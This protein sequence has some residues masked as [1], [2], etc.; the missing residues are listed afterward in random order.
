M[1]MTNKDFSSHFSDKF[2]PGI[3]AFGK[4]ALL[5]EG[6]DCLIVTDREDKEKAYCT[7]CKKWVT[8]PANT[9]HT[10]SPK[11]IQ[12]AERRNYNMHC[13]H[14]AWGMT[15]AGI[16]KEKAKKE[17]RL[18]IENRKHAICPVCKNTYEVYH[19]WR[20]NMSQLDGYISLSVWD[21]SKTE[22]GAV[23]M[24]RIE[25][26][27]EYGN[28]TEPVVTDTY[29]D[30]ER[31]LF[32][33]GH[34]TVRQN[35]V[36]WVKYR[37]VWCKG[38]WRKVKQQK[39]FVKSIIDRA[40]RQSTVMWSDYVHGH[41]CM[42]VGSL[43][44]AIRGTPYKYLFNG[45]QSY[46]KNYRQY[47]WRDGY[48]L[49][50]VALMDLYSLH[51]WVELL[52]KNGMENIV[53]NHI[54]RTGCKNA[55][56][57]A[58]KSIK[59]AVKRFTKQDLK[60]ILAINAGQRLVTEQDLAFLAETREKFLPK[61]TVAE[62]VVCQK[63]GL[64]TLRHVWERA[65]KLKV[66]PEKIVTYCL[67][68]CT[69][70]HRL[71]D[72][73][74]YIADA[75]KIGL[76]LSQGSNIFPRDIYTMHANISR[77]IKYKHDKELKEKLKATLA[78]RETL[79]RWE[80]EKYIIRPAANTDELIE[81]GKALHHCV[82]GYAQRHAD[83]ETNI[84]FIRKKEQPDVSFVT[85]EVKKGTK[86]TYYV[87]QIHGYMNDKTNPLPKEVEELA[88]QFIG[89]VNDRAKKLKKKA[90]KVA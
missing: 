72:W 86:G 7:H 10:G 82:G 41:Y 25:I 80:G 48:P 19:Q 49:Y 90:R 27:R 44:A 53:I 43:K 30:A 20:M 85:M 51:P 63:E 73:L 68:H 76:D 42:D 57:W 22:P 66:K 33:M 29:R 89:I 28:G 79:F 6:F 74:D 64:E 4:K 69:S 11:S 8:I 62:A 38:E 9:V 47:E 87:A 23:V 26:L 78:L 88:D 61:M 60:D 14:G 37:D 3:K 13:C 2:T 70:F 45:K 81:E 34:K 1:E 21:K 71:G 59:S 40:V 50:V 54:R 12:A 35:C 18:A 15:E 46:L 84:L 58:A 67:K 16:E 52:L 32:R 36:P 83:G 65:K 31:Y 39:F 56:C 55:I 17:R 75:G 5:I 77:Q 24:R